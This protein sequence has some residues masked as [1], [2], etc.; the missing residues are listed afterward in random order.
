MAWTAKSVTA[1]TLYTSW[2]S[3]GLS[4]CRTNNTPSSR[5][6]RMSRDNSSIVGW[7][8]GGSDGSGSSVP[9]TAQNDPL[10]PLSSST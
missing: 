10:W 4:V 3:G 8:L 5:L 9:Q 2:F 6:S 7:G 1:W